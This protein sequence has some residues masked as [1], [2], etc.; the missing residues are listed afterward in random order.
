MLRWFLTRVLVIAYPIIEI[1]LIV[2]AGNVIGWGWTLL[3]LA[4]CVV[5]G[6]LVMRAAG[7]D[8]LA[9]VTEPMRKHQPYVEIDETT[10]TARTIHPTGQPTP[11]EAEE[12]AARLRDSGLV[13]SA[14]ILIAVPGF[15]ST[16]AGLILLLPPV[17]RLAA[18]RLVRRSSGV[19]IVGE[20]LREPPAEYDTDT[21]IR[22]EILRG[23]N[24]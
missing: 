7:R 2:W 23:P 11:A 10:G 12:A 8:A 17:R 13:F 19:V 24:E 21:V 6:F 5:A 1:L 9:A 14:G 16:G 20:T 3:I 4:G 22:G 15:I 18:P